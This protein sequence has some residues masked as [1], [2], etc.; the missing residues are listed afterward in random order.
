MS[1]A[2]A[3]LVLKALRKGR[4]LDSICA[5]RLNGRHAPGEKITHYQLYRNYCVAHPDFSR[6]AEALLAEK[7]QGR[8]RTERCAPSQYDPLQLRAPICWRKCSLPAG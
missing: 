3:Q 6:E 2:T 7:Y 5:G 8:K 4:T 1:E